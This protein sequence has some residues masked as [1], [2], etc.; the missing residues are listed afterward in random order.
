VR[1]ARDPRRGLVAA[2]LVLAAPAPR[3]ALADPG[4]SPPPPRSRSLV[5]IE[6]SFDLPVLLEYGELGL[7][8]YRLGLTARVTFELASPR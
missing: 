7:A 5:D 6:A 1:R 8:T 3:A 4:V 2:A